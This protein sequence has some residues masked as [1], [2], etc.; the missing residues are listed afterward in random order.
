MKILKTLIAVSACL[1]STSAFSAVV[2]EQLPPANPYGVTSAGSLRLFDDFTLGANATIKS[3]TWWE[4]AVGPNTG[5]FEILFTRESGELPST[6]VSLGSVTATSVAD[7]YFTTKYTA[8]L[9][10]AVSL[11]AGTNYFLSIYRTDGDFV[12][13]A[14]LTGGVPGVFNG[15]AYS[16]LRVDGDDYGAG[17]NVA[18][19]LNDAALPGAVPEPASWAMMIAGIGAVGFVLRRKRTELQSI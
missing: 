6:T 18:W 17:L 11:T 16:I 2:V 3:V 12:W 19:S 9:P 4:Q 15:D 8:N 1:W 10:A 5:T 13:V 7:G 14:K